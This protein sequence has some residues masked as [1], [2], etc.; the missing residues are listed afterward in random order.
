MNTAANKDGIIFTGFKK[1][2]LLINKKDKR[3]SIVSLDDESVIIA[4]Q[5]Q[6][7]YQIPLDQLNKY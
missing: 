1:T 4:L 2:M 3:W 5:S 6:V 7:K